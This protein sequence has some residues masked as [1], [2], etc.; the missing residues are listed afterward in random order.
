MKYRIAG[1]G[2]VLIAF[3]LSLA[4]P[5]A[6]AAAILQLRTLQSWDLYIRQTE[7][8]IDGEL[9]NES[10]FLRL[11]GMKPADAAKVPNA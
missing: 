9:P 1:K 10:R 2:V 7:K 5:L 11:D 3:C 6:A 4:T 8:R